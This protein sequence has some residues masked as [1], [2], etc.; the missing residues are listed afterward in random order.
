MGG[1]SHECQS[2]KSPRPKLSANSIT[3]AQPSMIGVIIIDS[4]DT[5][6]LQSCTAQQDPADFKVAIGA[7]GCPKNLVPPPP[8]VILRISPSLAQVAV[9][10]MSDNPPQL[11]DLPNPFTPMAFLPPDEAF[12]IAIA[13]YIIVGSTAVLIWDILNSLGED[14]KLLTTRRKGIATLVYWLSRVATLG[15]ALTSTLFQTAPLTTHCTLF[16]KVNSAWF[17]FA[18]PTTALLFLLRIR[19]IFH[20]TKSVIYLFYALWLALLA[21]CLTAPFS[22]SAKRIGTTKYC[23][24][25]DVKVYTATA[26]V[27][28]LVYDTFVFLAISWKLALNHSSSGKRLGI[29]EMIKGDSLPIHS[30]ALLK[31]GQAYYLT[32]VITGIITVIMLYAPGVPILY[33]E[34]FTVPNVTLINI[35]ASRVFRT[36]KLKLG[37]PAGRGHTNIIPIA[38]SNGRTRIGPP[39]SEASPCGRDSAAYKPNVARSIGHVAGREATV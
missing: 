8:P 27:L 15:F 29:K 32:T 6:V 33:R 3:S 39:V 31:D 28:P 16:Q 35:M 36:T 11:S 14:Y 37:Q 23:I 38:L 30:K 21:G 1:S 5:L 13:T 7:V 10:I 22:T 20:R 26:I 18:T 12:Q 25:D 19:A 34:A 4:H 24:G 17:S 9:Y 2:F